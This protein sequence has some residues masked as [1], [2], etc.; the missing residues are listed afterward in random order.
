MIASQDT[1][2]RFSSLSS[3]YLC[4]GPSAAF[5]TAFFRSMG[6]QGFDPSVLS[7]AEASKGTV[8]LG[9]L[10][11]MFTPV[12]PAM[13]YTNAAAVMLGQQ[14]LPFCFGNCSYPTDHSA[15]SVKTMYPTAAALNNTGFFLAQTTGHAM[16]LHYRST[17]AS[18]FVGRFLH[19]FAKYN[20]GG[21]PACKYLSTCQPAVIS[22]Q[23]GK[24][25]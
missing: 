24:D 25:P 1:P 9:E 17:A 19:T 12:K 23:P 8:T 21:V 7:M 11:T 14:D 2:Y 6:G 3:S 16:N 20:P 5:Q 4:P 13:S 15:G 22:Y 18:A 10:F